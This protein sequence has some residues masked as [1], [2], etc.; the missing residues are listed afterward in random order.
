MKLREDKLHN[1]F[2]LLDYNHRPA[3]IERL[4]VQL[5]DATKSASN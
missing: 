5:Q 1:S 2:N 4:T 3:E